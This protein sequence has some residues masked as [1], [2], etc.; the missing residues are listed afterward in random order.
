[1]IYKALA[2]K[3]QDGLMKAFK[4][5]KETSLRIVAVKKLAGKREII[6]ILVNRGARQRAQEAFTKWRCKVRHEKDKQRISIIQMITIREAQRVK[7]AK[8][9]I[10][11]CF[12]KW[13]YNNSSL[14]IPKISKRQIENNENSNRLNVPLAPLMQGAPEK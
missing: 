6:L 1:M 8:S 14:H 7:S 5:W 10:T 4:L 11:K 9:S 2:L 13:R 12:F 3:A